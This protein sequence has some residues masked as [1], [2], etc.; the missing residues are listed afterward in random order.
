[1]PGYIEDRWMT[2]KPD[3]VTG[4]KRKTERWGKGK[5]YRV[6][7]IPGVKDRSFAKLHGPDGANAWLAKAQHE[8]VSG[9]FV[10]PRRG[11]LLLKDYIANEWWPRRAYENPSTEHTVKGRVWNH[12]IPHLGDHQLNGIKTAQLADWLKTLKATVGPGT[13]NEAWGYLS[14]IF[15]SAIDD[16]R[17]TRN[18]CRKQTTL[19]V[20]SKPPAKPR[21]WSK[22]RV[23]AVQEAMDERFRLCVDLGVGAGLRSGEVFGLSVADIDF[24]GRRILVRR[25]VRKV[26]SRLAFALPK[27]EKTREVPV[28]DYLLKRIEDALS[29]RPAQQITLPWGDPRPPATEREEKE[30]RPQT[31]ALIL[32]GARGGAIRRD[33]FDTRVWKPALAG[34]GV[35]PPP[36]VTTQPILH[37]SGGVRT[38]LTYAES[39]ENGFHALRHTFASVQLD[40]R[41]PIVAV[42]KWLGH[43]DPSITLRIYAH[44][45]PEAD[46]RGRSAMQNWFETL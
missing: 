32:T 1:M 29:R 8:S 5:R 19:N 26:G 2:K 9:E 11:H 14:S 46:G 31:H 27:G 37:R 35:I 33:T 12:I 18:P 21:A 6:A 40:A 10:D 15:Q 13:A 36:V 43:A 23:L 38:V 41:E 30:R 28:P 17:L 20:P 42:S 45:M 16:E 25:Q 24:D 4:E 3:P 44:M 34:A 39:R 22:E 7:G